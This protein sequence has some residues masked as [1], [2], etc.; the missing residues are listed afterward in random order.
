MVRVRRRWRR[1][2]LTQ[3]PITVPV[4][5]SAKCSEAACFAPSMHIIPARSLAAGRKTIPPTERQTDSG[6]MPH[7]PDDEKFLRHLNL[8]PKLAFPNEANDPKTL[9][10]CDLELLHW[11]ITRKRNYERAEKVLTSPFPLPHPSVPMMTPFA[12]CFISLST[13]RYPNGEKN[14]ATDALPIQT[15]KVRGS[16]E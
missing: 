16:S 5:E 10:H 13:Y 4:D 8:M 2:R 3:S 1:G 9:T 7:S 6:K 14:S 12:S 11:L 15:V